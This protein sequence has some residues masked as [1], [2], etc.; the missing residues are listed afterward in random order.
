MSMI[1]ANISLVYKNIYIRFVKRIFFAAPKL[2]FATPN[3]VA[4]HSLRNPALD[5][6]FS[7][8]ISLRHTIINTGFGRDT[9]TLLK[10]ILQNLC[11]GSDVTYRRFCQNIKHSLHTSASSAAH[12]CAAAHSLGNT[13]LDYTRNSVANWYI[14]IYQ[15]WKI[16]KNLIYQIWN[17]EKFGIFSKCWVYKFLIWYIGKIWY[18]FGTFL[19]EGLAEILN[20]YLVYYRAKNR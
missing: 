20:K 19:S 10:P 3:G 7:N 13:T 18:V 15:I 8:F 11:N 4:T 16:L 6:R 5:Q 14:Y 17:F 9:P 2:Y 12:Q 1:H